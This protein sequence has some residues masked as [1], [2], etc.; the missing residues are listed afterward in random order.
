MAKL[1]EKDAAIAPIDDTDILHL[2]QDVGGTPVSRKMTVAQLKTELDIPTE[3][4]IKAIAK[5]MAIIFG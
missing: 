2:V 3:A 5:N 1:T 4:E